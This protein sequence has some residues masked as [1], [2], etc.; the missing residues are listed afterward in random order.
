[1][2]DRESPHPVRAAQW[3]EAGASQQVDD[4]RQEDEADDGEK[5]QH[6]YVHHD[7]DG[8]GRDGQR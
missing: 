7:G 6:Q 2:Q 8:A 4:V 1:M 3:L 5:H